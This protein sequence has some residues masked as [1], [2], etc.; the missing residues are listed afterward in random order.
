MKKVL[1]ILLY[2][3]LGTLLLSSLTYLFFYLKWQRESRA[4]LALLAERAPELKV[5]GRT[6]RDLNKNGSLDVYEDGR[7]AIE[8]RIC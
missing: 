8:D 2:V 6:F 4:N 5:D 7:A 1:R 3:L